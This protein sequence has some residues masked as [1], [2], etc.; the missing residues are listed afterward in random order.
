MPSYAPSLSRLR[1]WF[2][3]ALVL[4]ISKGQLYLDILK[5]GKDWIH[6]DTGLELSLLDTVD[7]QIKAFHAIL[8]CSSCP[9]VVISLLD[10]ATCC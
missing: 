7:N 3:L 1:C 8:L 4:T 9:T 10:G 2:G 6:E 5:L